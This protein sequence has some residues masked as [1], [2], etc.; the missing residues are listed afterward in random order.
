VELPHPPLQRDIVFLRRYLRIAKYD[1]RYRL[2]FLLTRA[3]AGARTALAASYVYPKD[4]DALGLVT[5]LP[6]Y[7]V[8]II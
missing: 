7:D 8:D 3:G 1:M 2:A 4:L 5:P 6:R